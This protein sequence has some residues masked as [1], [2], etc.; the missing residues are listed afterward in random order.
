[1]LLLCWCT[2]LVKS[3]SWFF[4]GS[5]KT[6]WNGTIKKSWLKW[7][8]YLRSMEQMW[9][10]NYNCVLKENKLYCTV[11]GTWYVSYLNT[12][13]GLF[14]CTGRLDSSLYFTADY[15]THPLGKFDSHVIIDQCTWIV[16]NFS[17]LFC[18]K[19]FGVELIQECGRFDY[20]HK[21]RLQK[22][23]LHITVKYLCFF[24]Y[25]INLSVS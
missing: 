6:K 13:G 22:R 5:S 15:Y 4:L 25:L 7:S 20:C 14:I 9:T 24:L 2:V 10:I 16:F 17:S 11:N 21:N 19:K 1:M 23:W 8:I 18:D 12:F 3:S